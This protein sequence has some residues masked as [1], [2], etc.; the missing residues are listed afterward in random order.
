MSAN[1]SK[2]KN[3]IVLVLPLLQIEWHDIG[4]DRDLAF[5]MLFS[6]IA[7]SSKG[8]QMFLTSFQTHRL[9]GDDSFLHFTR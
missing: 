6:V 9:V 3:K 2:G 5:A 4:R 1:L 7:T 8:R